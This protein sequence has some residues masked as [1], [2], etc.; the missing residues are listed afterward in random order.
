[1]TAIDPALS[2]ALISA[3]YNYNKSMKL[4]T[5]IDPAL[6]LA[7]ISAFYN[8]NK[9]MKLRKDMATFKEQINNL[10]NSKGKD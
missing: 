9:S 3:F 8:Y 5:T 4:T 10:E 2:L 1:M 6:A 7:L